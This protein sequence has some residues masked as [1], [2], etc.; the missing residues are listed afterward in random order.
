MKHKFYQLIKKPKMLDLRKFL[1]LFN[2]SFS[3][4]ASPHDML[5][6]NLPNSFKVIQTTADWR[7]P[8]HKEPIC[9]VIVMAN[10]WVLLRST[11]K[12]SIQDSRE[13]STVIQTALK[14]PHISLRPVV[15]TP[16]N[17]FQKCARFLKWLLFFP[18]FPLFSQLVRVRFSPFF[19]SSQQNDFFCWKMNLNLNLNQFENNFISRPF[20]ESKHFRFSFYVGEKKKKLNK[21]GHCL[22][23]W[24][25]AIRVRCGL[26]RSGSNIY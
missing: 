13:K 19:S 21:T 8:S 17:S 5:R 14:C 15:F 16:L 7:K 1:N 20:S 3:A 4:Y 10:C 12:Y 6:S 9:I 26:L 22:S 23:S 25:A 11:Q 24:L 2:S 18:S